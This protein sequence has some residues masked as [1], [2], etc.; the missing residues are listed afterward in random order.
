MPIT[1]KQIHEEIYFYGLIFTAVSLPLSIYTTTLAQILL[2]ANWIAEGR[3]REKWEHFRSNRALWIFLSLY[4]LHAIG[5][6]WSDDGAYSFQDMKGKAA[7]L[8]IPLVVGTSVPLNRKQVGWIL[9]LFTM[10]VFAG[11]IA[12]LMALAGWLPV[13]VDNYRDLSLFISHIRF[14]LM[15]VTAILAIVYYLF[16]RHS[17]L[18][19]FERIFY[20]VSLVWFPVFLVVLKSLSGIAIL[21][22][23]AF[24]LLVRA[25]V[26]IR[27][28]V[29][30]F[31]VFVPVIM[32]PVFSIFYLGRAVNKYYTI[33][34]PAPDDI[35]QFTAE[36]NPYVNMP[37]RREVE[38][39]HFVWIHVCE[40]ELEREWNRV[41]EIDY[42]GH[43]INGNSIRGTLIRYLTSRGLRKDAAGISQLSPHE[44]E[45][46]ELGVANHIYLQR[47]RLYPRIYEVIWEI[48]RY[49]MGYPANGKSVVQR[50]LYLEAGWNIAK[51]NLLYGVGNG[52]VRQAF[53]DYYE[54]VNSPLEMK[55][56]RRAHNQ[57]L[58]FI[59]AFGLIGGILCITALVAPLFITGRQHSFLAIGFFIL[60]LLSMISEDTLETSTGA[61]FV[62]FFYTL[63]VFGPE[64]PWLRR[65]ILP[66]Q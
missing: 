50:Y 29:V 44:I 26:E 52:D 60:M 23:L 7:L 9:L 45:A 24:F 32:I 12:S 30:R 25:V 46:I 49:R 57:F 16:I 63:F 35:D 18:S 58:T 5:L 33:E 59:I 54:S 13:Q 42:R 6:L 43:T 51:E 47:F 65:R 36:G 27:D 28:P 66:G 8:V 19:R 39:G 11:S 10:G 64:T 17:S 61:A 20:I 56:R 14:S 4:L 15:I 40:E 2:L 22:F 48:D 3:F 34:N 62:A 38:N 55:W 21:G 37:E 31:M 1:R 41:S 53:R